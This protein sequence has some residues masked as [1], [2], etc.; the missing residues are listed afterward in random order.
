MRIEITEQMLRDALLAWE[1]EVPPG[2]PP[3][4]ASEPVPPTL[5]LVPMSV[6]GN[7]IH[8]TR[9]FT[10]SL[11]LHADPSSRRHVARQMPVLQGPQQRCRHPDAAAACPRSCAKRCSLVT[12]RAVVSSIDA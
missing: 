5:L 1:R 10:P 12:A 7:W 8:E 2:A 11:R 6:V 9:R 3:P 4:E